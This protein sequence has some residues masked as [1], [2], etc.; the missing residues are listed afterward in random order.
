MT[1]QF[2]IPHPAS[3][4]CRG[5]LSRRSR[6]KTEAQHRRVPHR[7]NPSIRCHLPPFL[8]S[9]ATCHSSRVTCA[10]CFSGTRNRKKSSFRVSQKHPAIAN[11]CH[12]R[13]VTATNMQR[14][15][16][17]EGGAEDQPADFRC[18][19]LLRS[20]IFHLRSSAPAPSVVSW[21]RGLVV[22]GLVVSRLRTSGLPPL[23]S[24]S[25]TKSDQVRALKMNPPLSTLRS[26][27][28]LSCPRHDRPTRTCALLSPF[29]ALLFSENARK[30]RNHTE[31]HTNTHVFIGGGRPPGTP[32]IFCRITHHASCIHFSVPSA[33]VRPSPAFESASAN[34]PTL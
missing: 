14:A 3:R 8:F 28:L 29:F 16:R 19:D 23:A 10:A 24:C 32:P 4:T 12:T 5:G 7:I 1:G 26:P 2:R 17:A 9:P 25:Q 30:T 11:L 33:Q 34:P 21:S 27:V 22:S 18:P 20:S 15:G 31:Q 6:T 13:P